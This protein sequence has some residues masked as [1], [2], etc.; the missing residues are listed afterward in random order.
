MDASIS[1]PS[2]SP[3]RL[4]RLIGPLIVEQFL[5]VLIGMVDTVMVSS[6]GEGAVSAVALVDSINIL[7]LNIFT[8]LAAGGAIVASQYL[9]R[10][11]VDN[12]RRSA[13]QLV[14]T[15]SGI[16]LMI[17][18]V[19]C[20]FSTPIL[21]ALYSGAGDTI[22]NDAANYFWV[23]SL[24]YPFIAAYSCGTAIFRAQGNS[25]ISMQAALLS[26]GINIAGNALCIYGLGWGVL[27]AAIPT[28]VSRIA[29][30]A[31]ILV[32]LRQP[33]LTISLTGWREFKFRPAMIRRILGVGLPNSL[34]SSMFHIGKLMVQTLISTLGAVAIAAN[35]VTNSIAS[36]PQ[37][38]A[39]AI[40]LAMTTVVGQ[41]VG[42]GDYDAARRYV[43]RLMRWAVAAMLALC[44]VF[45]LLT[46]TLLQ[47]FHLSAAT[48]ELAQKVLWD[49]FAIASVTWVWS[50][51]L[52]NGLR[53]A[54][55]VKFTML[56]SIASMWIF[57]IGF[58]YLFVWQYRMGLAGVWY[59]MYLDWIVRICCFVIR[60]FHGRWKN[61]AV[62]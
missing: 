8:A 36:L 40:G 11:E 9:G 47:L 45:F 55:D 49:Y 32:L 23:T 60:F 14:V 44:A 19:C 4:R 22:L 34:E 28:L 18:L 58:S 26:N 5:A 17:G 31:M 52:P 57:R 24:S 13:R 25:R 10:G 6:V 29:G 16:G 12:A 43:L 21:R 54:G 37:I 33:N 48:Q 56:C 30:A 59:A 35:A 62:I 20:I 2:F 51:T 42:A 41:C 39:V 3:A 7:A 46:P 53:A 38:P 61:R 15:V 1:T 27:G 50:F